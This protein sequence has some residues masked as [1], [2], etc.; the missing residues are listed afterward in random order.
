MS[1]MW[2]FMFS[3]IAAECV[4]SDVFFGHQSTKISFPIFTTFYNQVFRFSP[5]PVEPSEHFSHNSLW[6]AKSGKML[7][8]LMSLNFC[9]Q[10]QNL[11]KQ[12]ERINPSC[13]LLTI[14]AADV[15]FEWGIFS[16]HILGSLVPT[17]HH[18]N[19]AAYLSI[20]ADHV[21]L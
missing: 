15:I 13:L 21:H 20:A 19:T 11:N 6:L 18:L 17:E 12:Y 14:Q 3:L 10:C 8:V 16:G 7:P 2:L 9:C 4:S 5:F 1:C